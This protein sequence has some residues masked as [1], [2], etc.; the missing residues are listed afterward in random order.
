MV[1]DAV[2]LKPGAGDPAAK[3]FL[4]FLKSPTALAIIKRY[5]Y[6]VR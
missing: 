4:A 5:G 3:A 1:Q 6:D 2:L